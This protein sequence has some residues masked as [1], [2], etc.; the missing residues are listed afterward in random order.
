L[1]RIVG[2]QKSE[3]ANSEFVLLQNQGSMRVN[4][5]GHAVLSEDAVDFGMCEASHVFRD[6]VHLAPGMYAILISGYGL[7][8]WRRTKDGMNVYH[9]YMGRDE[10]I[11]SRCRLPLHV[12]CTQHSYSEKPE[13][14]LLR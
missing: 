2:V 5:R 14:L 11:W 1:L 4:L 3:S 8:Q 12:L 6:D 7:N 13:P 10:V 9:V